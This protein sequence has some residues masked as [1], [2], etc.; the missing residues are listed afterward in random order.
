MQVLSAHSYDTLVEL[1]MEDYHKDKLKK[2]QGSF[3]RGGQALLWQFLGNA[4]T[5]LHTTL[6]WHLLEVITSCWDPVL[7]CITIGDMDLVPTLE[8]YDH[9][10]FFS[11]PVSTLFILLV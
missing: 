6:D 4:A 5:L 8:E 1:E 7:R 10:L 3:S 11:T 2:W 9:F